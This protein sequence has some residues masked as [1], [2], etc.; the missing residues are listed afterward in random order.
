MC[1]SESFWSTAPLKKNYKKLQEVFSDWC[2]ILC[3]FFF[4]LF[5]FWGQRQGDFFWGEWNCTPARRWLDYLHR[6]CKQA[7]GLY[8]VI[9]L[10]HTT[11]KACVK[12][13][14]LHVHFSNTVEM[15]GFFP[16][17]LCYLYSLQM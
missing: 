13:Q 10:L 17:L 12:K 16:M 11:Q 2:D 6:Q 7:Q 5:F 8:E 4:G 14:T 1:L 15:C 3:G 9:F